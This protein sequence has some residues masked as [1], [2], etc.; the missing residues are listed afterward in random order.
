MTFEHVK[1]L[2]KIKSP[3]EIWN[4][5]G[6]LPYENG[7]PIDDGKPNCCDDDK[8]FKQRGGGGVGGGHQQLY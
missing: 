7:K 8:D 4:Y 6:F 3:N 2:K 5:L 1:L